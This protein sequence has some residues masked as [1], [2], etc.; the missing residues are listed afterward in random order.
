M[1]EVCCIIRHSVAGTSKSKDRQRTE[2]KSLGSIKADARS[3]DMKAM[4]EFQTIASM[5]EDPHEY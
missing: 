2:I 1:H 5:E 3:K 4:K